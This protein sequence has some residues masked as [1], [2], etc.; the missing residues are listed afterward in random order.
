[1]NE[2]LKCAIML[3]IECLGLVKFGEGDPSE[4]AI[5]GLYNY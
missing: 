5:F 4:R 3:N 1:M 2:L